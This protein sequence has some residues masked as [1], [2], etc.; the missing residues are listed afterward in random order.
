MRTYLVVG[1]VVGMILVGQAGTLRGDPGKETD[2]ERIARLIKQLGDDSFAKREAA[3]KELEGIGA[4]A[5]AALRKAASSSA[6]PEIRRRAKR[7][8]EA[9]TEVAA[10]ADDLT[11]LQAKWRW[12]NEA[13]AN[14]RAL[15][16]IRSATGKRNGF[17][18]GR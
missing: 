8:E 7:I 2:A 13:A 16:H 12:E 15:S 4:P 14:M 10:Q 6:D 18:P 9:I 5:L 1:T 11:K 3:S 17:V